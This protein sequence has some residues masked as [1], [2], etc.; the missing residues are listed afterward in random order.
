MPWRAPSREMR[1]KVKVTIETPKR[2]S[3]MYEI[4]TLVFIWKSLCIC[5]VL[6]CV[7]TMCVRCRAA[8]DVMRLVEL[9][10]VLIVE[11]R[12]ALPKTPHPSLVAKRMESVQGDR[13]HRQV[14]EAI[15]AGN[16][17]EFYECM[18][19][20][21]KTALLHHLVHQVPPAINREIVPNRCTPSPI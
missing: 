11:G 7:V 10:L 21:K 19:S 16:N 3:I 2:V 8:L 20:G 12:K 1:G 9:L 13:S 14:I 6:C 5:L 17:E 4:S 15:R 18:D